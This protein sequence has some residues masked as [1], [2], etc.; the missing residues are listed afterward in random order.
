M[1]LLFLKQVVEIVGAVY[2]LSTVVIVGRAVVH[3]HKSGLRAAFAKQTFFTFL[4]PYCTLNFFL[5]T[6]RRAFV[7]LGTIYFFLHVKHLVLWFN[8]TNHDLTL[9]NFDRWLHFGY[10]PNILAMAAIS[11][12]QVLAVLIDWLY[13]KYFV[14]K[15]LI[16]LFFLLETHGRKLTDA[17][18]FAYVMLWAFG[19]IGYLLYPADGP[20]YAVLGHNSVGPSDAELHHV[21][22]FPITT[23]VPE[24][25]IDQYAESKIWTAKA[26]QVELWSDRQAFLQGKR[27][28]GMF[29]GIAAMPSLHVAAV[30]F[31]AVFLFQV[32]SVAGAFASLYACVIFIGSMFLQWHYAADGYAGLLVAI[33]ICVISLRVPQAFV[34]EER[35]P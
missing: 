13:F 7:V 18:I 21:F 14:Y 23:N 10:Q 26:F 3:A 12:Y 32:S 28:P 27:L 24:S 1:A 15:L 25:Y 33:L 30:V 22:T 19:C 17:Y 35:L 29:Y 8:Q 6:V 9:W 16:A 31:I 4:Y 20:C 11:P 2:A 34:K 5:L